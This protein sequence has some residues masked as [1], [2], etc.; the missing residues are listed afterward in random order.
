MSKNKLKNEKIKRKYLA[1]LVDAEGYS[2]KTIECIEKALWKFE[3]FT[4]EVRKL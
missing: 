1:W 3:E 2:K 4:K